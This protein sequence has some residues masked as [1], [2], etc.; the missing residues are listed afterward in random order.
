MATPVKIE[1]EVLGT[2]LEEEINKH[3]DRIKSKIEIDGF[4]KGEVSQTMA[5]K[6]LGFQNLYKDVIPFIYHKNLKDQKVNIIY[7]GYPDYENFEVFGV[8]QHNG[9]LKIENTVFLYPK[10]ELPDIQNFKVEYND[11]NMVSTEEVDDYIQNLLNDNAKFINVK[12]PIQTGDHIVLD[13]EGYINNEKFPHGTAKDYSLVVGSNTLIPGFE[14]QLIGLTINDDKTINVQFPKNYKAEGLSGKDASFK[15]K[16]KSISEKH[17][18]TLQDY[19]KKEHLNIEELKLQT[20]QKLLSERQMEKDK[21][22]KQECLTKYAKLCKIEP[23]PDIVI[24]KELNHKFEAQ[25]EAFGDKKE[26]L[27]KTPDFFDNYKKANYKSIEDGI[28]ISIILEH[29]VDKLPIII[30]ENEL[31]TYLSKKYNQSE[32]VL[33]ILNDT[34]KRL[35]N[36]YQAKLDKAIQYILTTAKENYKKCQNN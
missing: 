25:L 26:E 17:N 21:L 35:F 18:L 10:I 15:I 6:H 34:S 3:W 1:L 4:R 11:T 16:I 36:E 30:D 28:R 24:E 27:L 31:K 29:L 32:I 23:V 14:D 9:N 8:F 5:E 7:D 22:F 33:E 13:F 19:L 12:R 20:V 2:E